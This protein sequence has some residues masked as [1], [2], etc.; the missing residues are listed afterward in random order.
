V[1]GEPER[2]AAYPTV[3]AIIERLSAVTEAVPQVKRAYAAFYVGHDGYPLPDDRV[4]VVTT[5]ATG[6][7][8]H[9]S[10]HPTWRKPSTG[11]LYRACCDLGIAPYRALML[12]D[13]DDDKNAAGR[14][15]IGFRRVTPEAWQPGFLGEW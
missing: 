5:L 12:G 3:E 10:W 13:S 14:L 4:D 6:V 1:R 2:A 8:F 15:D 11:M 7:P 9:G